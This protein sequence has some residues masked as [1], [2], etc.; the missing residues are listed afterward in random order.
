MSFTILCDLCGKPVGDPG[1]G[2]RRFKIKEA[3]WLY[4]DWNKSRLGWR[5]IDCHQKC[6]EKLFG[7]TAAINRPI[8]EVPFNKEPSAHLTYSVPCSYECDKGVNKEAGTE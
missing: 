4:T 6:I 3:S 7:A 5:E 2:H 8:E 1:S